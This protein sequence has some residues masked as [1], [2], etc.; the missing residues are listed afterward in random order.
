MPQIA[1]SII[2]IPYPANSLEYASRFA[3]STGFIWLDSGTRREY[4]GQYDLI[5]AYPS[6]HLSAQSATHIDIS[7][8][9][10]TRQVT[11]QEAERWCEEYSR[12]K[13][14]EQADQAVAFSG[15]LLGYIGYEWNHP[16]FKLAASNSLA[17]PLV[18]LGVYEWALVID[19]EQHT[20]YFVFTENISAQHLQQIMAQFNAPAE[21]QSS[22]DTG[23]F[24]CGEFKPQTPKSQYLQDI[25]TI[26]DFINAGDCYQV[27]YSQ[28][29]SAQF[30]GD[31]FAAYCQLR[32]GCPGPF[33]A[34]IST[35]EGAILSLSPEQFIQIDT[36]NQAISRPIKGTA[37]RHKN[38]Q[39][40]G[41][42]AR[43][44]H[45]SV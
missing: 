28:A 6:Q 15:G 11:L 7:Q 35:A 5:S 16:K 42:L 14:T 3:R 44:L 20:A 34:F 43:E 22:L 25:N 31:A 18:Y 29:F 1:L 2:S 13:N 27:N 39:Q 38:T 24:Y 19:H 10:I 26:L 36:A 45:R 30:S 23:E 4:C 40:D 21:Y 9:G 33:S 12:P 37:A 32:S 17:T 8:G 41:S